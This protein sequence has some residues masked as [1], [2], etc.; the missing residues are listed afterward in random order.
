M[1]V[2]AAELCWS[3]DAADASSLAGLAAAAADEEEVA[4]DGHDDR[5]KLTNGIEC[6]FLSLLEGMLGDVVEDV[7]EG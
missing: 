3:L 2:V 7:E 5:G 1:F 4:E 6:E